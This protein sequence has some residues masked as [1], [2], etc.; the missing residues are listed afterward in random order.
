MPGH[1]I[2]I[3]GKRAAGEELSKRE[4]RA[5]RIL[6]AAA[7]LIQRWGYKKTAIDDIA[8]LAGV[9]KGTIYLHWKTREDLFVALF[10]REAIE[11]MKA[12]TERID[13]DPA[14]I[15]LSSVIKNAM[16]V[17]MTRPLSRALF[18]R[19]VSVLGELL[20][21]GREDL[22]TLSQQKLLAGRQ[23][24][25]FFRSK[26]ALRI[27]QDLEEQ[28]KAYATMVIGTIIVDQYMPADLQSSPEESAQRLAAMIRD[29]LEPTEPLSPETQQELKTTWDHF[30]EQ[31]MQMLDKHL[32]KGA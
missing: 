9:A 18:I 27:D 7:E 22:E 17:I 32:Q 4:E 14:G 5:H 16:Y 15:R 26:G 1:S 3:A 21:Q 11:T 28:I 31:I 23:L 20:Q 19:D 30:V 12:M 24:L 10:L 8:R 29:T 25:T 2:R 6:D 13:S